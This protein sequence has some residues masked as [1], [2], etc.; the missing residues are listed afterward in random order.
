MPDQVPSSTAA[1]KGFQS[2]SLHA[3]SRDVW[4][5]WPWIEIFG[6]NKSAALTM[7]E[8]VN[9]YTQTIACTQQGKQGLEDREQAH[10]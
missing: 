10:M 9:A 1:E 8:A 6:Q 3:R 2:A 7:S 4:S 5:H